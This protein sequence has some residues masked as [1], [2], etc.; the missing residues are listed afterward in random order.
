MSGFLP[1]EQEVAQK[2]HEKIL[3]TKLDLKLENKELTLEFVLFTDCLETSL[4]DLTQSEIYESTIVN[5]NFAEKSILFLFGMI[6]EKPAKFLHYDANKQ[7]YLLSLGLM[8]VSL[9]K[10]K[11]ERSEQTRLVF[12]QLKQRVQTLER[13]LL[14]QRRIFE[15]KLVSQEKMIKMMQTETEQLIGKK[16]TVGLQKYAVQPDQWNF[17]FSKINDEWS[18]I[19]GFSKNVTIETVSVVKI[20]LQGHYN[21]GKGRMFITVEIDDRLIDPQRRKIQEF[22][23]G[24]VRIE[25]KNGWGDL[26]ANWS[27]I[28]QPGKH[29][30]QIVGKANFNCWLHGTLMT[31]TVTPNN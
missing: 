19:D 22:V 26:S 12:E 28:L 20:A 24:A 2:K 10:K 7:E 14:D 8:E 30:I 17:I 6:E 9:K 31:V 4:S 29:H 15:D 25:Q 13:H 27:H 16:K 23:W 21:T 5:Q 11:M 1:I 3:T 18:A